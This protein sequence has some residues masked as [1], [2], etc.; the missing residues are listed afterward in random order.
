MP[1][2]CGRRADVVRGGGNRRATEAGLAIVLEL[3]RG[4]AVLDRRAADPWRGG[5]ETRRHVGH[6]EEAGSRGHRQL[7][8][9][10]TSAS[11]GRPIA[12]LDRRDRRI[13]DDVIA[14]RKV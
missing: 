1:R 6:V 12:I 5:G 8:S 14:V 4:A 3:S 9:K 11:G 2:A 10:Q 13:S 7:A